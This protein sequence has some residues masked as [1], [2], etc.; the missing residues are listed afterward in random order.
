[1]VVKFGKEYLRE[2]FEEGRCLDKHNDISL[3]LSGSIC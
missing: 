2:L 1:M 3:R